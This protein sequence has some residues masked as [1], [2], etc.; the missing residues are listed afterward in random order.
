M[1]RD[2]REREAFGCDQGRECLGFH[3]R[4]APHPRPPGAG[5]C[6][7]ALGAPALGPPPQTSAASIRSSPRRQTRGSGCPGGQSKRTRKTPETRTLITRVEALLLRA[8]RHQPQPRTK[9]HPP[10][11]EL[12]PHS[13]SR[14]QCSSAPGHL[15]APHSPRP[16]QPADWPGPRR[17]GPGPG[18]SGQRYRR[19]PPS[20]VSAPLPPRGWA[21]SGVARSQRQ[22]LPC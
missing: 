8:L 7:R 13:R 2:P 4:G 5:S 16:A 17:A 21:P 14:P 6:G 18:R 20:R 3:S 1:R 11:G 12:I 10:D 9:P 22:A 15:A 19:C